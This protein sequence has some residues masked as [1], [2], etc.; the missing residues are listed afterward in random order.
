MEKTREFLVWAE[1]YERENG[2]CRWKVV[3][4][5]SGALIG[6][7]GFAHPHETF[8]IELGYLFARSAWDAGYATEI[9][10]ATTVYGF[11]NLGFREIIALTDIEN[12][13]SQKVLRK[14]GFSERG[15]EIIKGEK[16]LVYIKK[17]SDE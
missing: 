11:A 17:K 13:A 5:S 10:H 16:N 1:N 14:I 7:C 2:F 12:T 3:E 8:E 4:K 6:S 9:A 15:V